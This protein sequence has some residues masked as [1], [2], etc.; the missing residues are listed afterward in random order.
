[1]SKVKTISL[2]LQ[3]INFDTDIIIDRE[4]IIYYDTK[5]YLN[6]IKF[7]KMKSDSSIPMK[8]KIDS[9]SLSNRKL[10]GTTSQSSSNRMSPIKEYSGTTSQ[11]SSNRM[12]PIKEYSGT[13]SQSS[14]NRMSP[15]KNSKKKS[16]KSSSRMSHIKGY[17]GK[18]LESSSSIMSA[19][20]D[21]KK[22]SDK[23]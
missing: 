14:S 23:S 22:K 16:D 12:S 8:S 15:I 5:K 11:S 13:T 19:V 4:D 6:L 20:K 17:S 18:T 3:K 21:T 9:K 2:P 1:M 10:S 7:K